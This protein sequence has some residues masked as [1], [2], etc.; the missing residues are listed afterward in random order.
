[1]VLYV[2][3]IFERRR[4]DRLIAAFDLVA[5]R[6]PD[7]TLEIVGENRTRHPRLDLDALKRRATHGDRI[8]IRSYVDEA[9]LAALYRDAAVF[10][11]LSEYEGFGLTPLEALVRGVP[12]IV[13]DT[14]VARETLDG[15][16]RYVGAAASNDEIAVAIA[17]LLTQPDTRR[18]V[19]DHAGEVLARY[20]WDRAG[21]QTLAV[22]EE[23]AVGR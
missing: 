22:L 3:S 6:V 19:L 14:P 7:A 1:M 21:A 11:F 2:G 10:A 4:V 5:A 13:L 8:T 23:A 16:A 17:D 18:G 20:D 12:P 15:A 9:T